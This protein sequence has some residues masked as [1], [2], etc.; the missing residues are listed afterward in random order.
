MIEKIRDKDALFTVTAYEILDGT[1]GEKTSVRSGS[2]ADPGDLSLSGCKLV[3]QNG[4]E[5]QQC[6]ICSC[7]DAAW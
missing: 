2:A 6:V 3:S 4:S 1:D 5:L 7:V